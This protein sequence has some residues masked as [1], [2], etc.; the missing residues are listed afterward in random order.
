MTD[1]GEITRLGDTR[2]ECDGKMR[3]SK[4]GGGALHIH[5]SSLEFALFP[6]F[7]LVCNDRAF[8]IKCVFLSFVKITA[9]Y[10]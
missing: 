5:S 2:R 9:Q 1:G 10:K 3:E 4:G 7:A 6:T 8:K